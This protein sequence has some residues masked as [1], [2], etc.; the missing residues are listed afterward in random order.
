MKVREQKCGSSRLTIMLAIV[1][2]LF[3]GA[4][5]LLGS[6]PAAAGQVQVARITVVDRGVSAEVHRLDDAKGHVLALARR[7]GEAKFKGGQSAKYQ[8][9][10]L[11]DAWIGVKGIRRG[12]SKL[13]FADG[14]EIYLAWRADSKRNQANLPS[15]KGHGSITRGTGRFKGITGRLL[16]SGAQLKP[17]SE[18]PRRTRSTL[19]V[20]VYTLP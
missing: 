2:V 13:S 1:A 11:I 20:L 19:V 17:T 16:L 12:Y 5:L 18:D 8:A 7:E 9:W 3:G 6:G 10:S 14:S 4:W 15:L